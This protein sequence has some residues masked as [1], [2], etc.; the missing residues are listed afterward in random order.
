LG[1]I[2]RSIPQ[3]EVRKVDTTKKGSGAAAEVVSTDIQQPDVE[4]E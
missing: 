4:E 3:P 2:I 1:S